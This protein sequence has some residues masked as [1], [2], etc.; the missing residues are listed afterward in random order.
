MDLRP[1]HQE[2]C[3]GPA[4]IS[5]TQ[6]GTGALVAYAYLGDGTIIGETHPQ[7]SGGLNLAVGLDRFGRV[8]D[9][10]WTNGNNDVLDEYT[11]TYDASGNRT[12]R[13]NVLDTDLSEV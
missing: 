1:P 5:T 12:S 3:I 13:G 4:N 6:S 8:T 9:Q 2:R 11:Y 7:V 10:K